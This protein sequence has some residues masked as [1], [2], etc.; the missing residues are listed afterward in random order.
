MLVPNNKQRSRLFHFAGTARFAF[1]LALTEEKINHEAGGKFLSDAELRKR[2]T[3][4]KQDNKYRWLYTISSNVT[5]QAVEDAAEAFRKFFNGLAK[6]PKYKSRKHSKPGF[7]VDTV[8]IKFT[9]THVKLES[10]ATGGKRNRQVINWFRP[11]EHER[12]PLN[13]KY[14][15]P[16]VSFDGLHWFLTV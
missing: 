7:Y 9:R 11:A 5:K 12:I 3:Q 4:L 15:N 13:A 6:H 1:N 16:Q 14:F 10:I 8:K 2:F